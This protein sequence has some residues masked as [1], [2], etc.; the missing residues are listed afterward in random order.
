M[1]VALVEK[2]FSIRIVA[3]VVVELVAKIFEFAVVATVPPA[4]ITLIVPF[5]ALMLCTVRLFAAVLAV[6]DKATLPL[7]VDNEPS[8]FKLL[9]AVNL[10]EPVPLTDREPVAPID[11]LLPEVAV[12]P[13]PRT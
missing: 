9:V 12:K 6:V 5:T 10:I 7:A 11:K 8:A 3:F 4:P 2:L 1:L 13:V